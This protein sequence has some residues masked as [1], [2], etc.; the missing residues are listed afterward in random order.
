MLDA[1]RLEKL[2]KMEQILNQTEALMQAMEAL[3]AEWQTL[4]PQINELFTYYGNGE[5]MADYQ[6]YEEGKIPAGTPCGVLSEDSVYNLIA[7]QQSVAAEWI[8]L[9]SRIE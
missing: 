7:Q 9:A 3:Q 2:A 4:Q 8:E 6:A 1:Q 5:W